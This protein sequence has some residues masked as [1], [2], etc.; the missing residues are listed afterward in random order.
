VV[1]LSLLLIHVLVFI[2]I[3]FLISSVSRWPKSFLA[4]KREMSTF[5][6]KRIIYLFIYL[7][8]TEHSVDMKTVYDE[9]LETVYLS[10]IAFC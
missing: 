6:Y 10:V 9:D 3:F 8:K 4:T 2:L 5:L 1:Y 7:F